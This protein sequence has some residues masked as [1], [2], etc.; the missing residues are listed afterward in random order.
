M[1]Y[2]EIQKYYQEKLRQYGPTAQGMDWK[3]ESTQYLRFEKIKDFISFENS[4][5]IL[6]VGCGASE[7][8]NFCLK[9]QISCSYLGL[10]LVKEM[11]QFSNDRFDKEVAICGDLDS[12][13]KSNMF[14]YVIASGTFNAKLNSSNEE[15]EKFFHENI[16][17]MYEIC[18]KGIIFNCMT[19]HVDWEYER[20]YYPNISNLTSFIVK[21]ISRKFHINHSYDLYEMT[22]FIVK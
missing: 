12:L 10:D 15:W 17:K 18:N 4:P 1:D 13:G 2:N 19:E 9:N 20:L 8:F 16:V 5:S 3:N 22:I 6:D 14:D 11:V 7:F 21:N